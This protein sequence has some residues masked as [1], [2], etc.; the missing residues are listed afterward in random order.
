MWIIVVSTGIKHL[1]RVMRFQPGLQIFGETNIKGLTGGA[2]E[3]IDVGEI[4]SGVPSRSSERLLLG[5]VCLARL[6]YTTAR[7]S[8]LSAKAP[9]EDWCA[10]RGLNSQPSASEADAL[11]N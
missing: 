5:S 6:R 8:S 4:H 1:T 7:Q 10:R 2:F 3:N 9:S 11:S